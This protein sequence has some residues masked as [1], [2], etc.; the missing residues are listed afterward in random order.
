LQPEATVADA[1]SGLRAGQALAMPE[2]PCRGD[3]FHILQTVQSLA[4]FLENRAYAAID[5]HAKLDR[6]TKRARRRGKRTQTL[7]RK[8]N[9]AGR[10]ADRAVALAD[11][12][13]LLLNWLRED[14][15]SLAGPDHGTRRELFDFLVAELRRGEPLCAHRIG[16][17]VRALSNQRD[18]LLAFAADLDKN[19]AAVAAEFQMPINTVRDVLNIEALD[20]RTRPVGLVS[21]RCE[22]NSADGSLP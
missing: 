12:V 4:T 17:V 6:Q 18:D 14:V 2:V 8:R 5:A 16:P 10:A 11:D 15:L 20:R 9:S 3:V 22:N 7:A 21:P 1:G 13:A 19:L